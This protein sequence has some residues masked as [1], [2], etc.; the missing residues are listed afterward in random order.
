MHRCDVEVV[1]PARNEELLLPIALRS[2]RSAIRAVDR[3]SHSGR[4]VI[5]GGCFP[6]AMLETT[7]V[8][9]RLTVVADRCTDRTVDIARNWADRVLEVD[10]GSPG[11]ARARLSAGWCF[12]VAT[13]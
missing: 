6:A 5:P 12:T 4:A 8:R 1:V 9:V 13:G 11:I 7:A 2:I 3:L 10:S